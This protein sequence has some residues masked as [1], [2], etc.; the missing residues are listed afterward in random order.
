ML[1]KKVLEAI[2]NKLEEKESLGRY[3]DF[4]EVEIERVKFKGTRIVISGFDLDYNAKKL[5]GKIIQTFY[6][7]YE[8]GEFEVDCRMS[9]DSVEIYNDGFFQAYFSSGFALWDDEFQY[10]ADYDMNGDFEVFVADREDA[11]KKE[12]ARGKI[13]R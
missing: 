6:L 8:T 5:L 13:A 2:L 3:A 7:N 10:V 4:R 9:C 11:G 1:M 12:I